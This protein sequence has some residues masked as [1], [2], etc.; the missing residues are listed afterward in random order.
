MREFEAGTHHIWIGCLYLM[1]DYTGD[2]YTKLGDDGTGHRLKHV[3]V[4][5]RNFVLDA[6]RLYQQP[7][8]SV[9]IP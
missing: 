8:I 1:K 7:T 4:D 5:G 2:G 3:Y 6:T 9:T